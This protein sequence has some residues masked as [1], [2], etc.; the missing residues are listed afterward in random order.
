MSKAT[1][2][3]VTAEISLV[4]TVEPM[5]LDDWHGNKYQVDRVRVTYIDPDEKDD[6][7]G[8]FYNIDLHGW[9]LLPS[10]KIDKRQKDRDEVYR[11]DRSKTEFV[12]EEL[13]I[14]YEADLAARYTDITKEK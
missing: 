6:P 14:D 4:Y 7:G 12:Q 8:P 11:T 1:S 3:N 10:G 13:G 2:L 9:R 5:E